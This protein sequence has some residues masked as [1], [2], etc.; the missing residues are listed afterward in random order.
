MTI[1]GGG[2]RNATVPSGYATQPDAATTAKS[3]ANNDSCRCNAREW[4]FIQQAD[5]LA[6]AEKLPAIRDVGI[7]R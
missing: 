4:C 3:K 1:G 7:A 2:G 6:T 5:V